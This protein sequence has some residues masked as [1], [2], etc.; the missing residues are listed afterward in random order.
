M[1][2]LSQRQILVGKWPARMVNLC[3]A[4]VPGTLFEA[5]SLYMV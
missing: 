2:K 3:F 1:A 4:K 5:S